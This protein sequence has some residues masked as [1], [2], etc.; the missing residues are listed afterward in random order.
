M[1]TFQEARSFLLQHRT[2]YDAAV[3]GFRWPDPVPFNW[4]LD[5]FDAELARDAESKDRAGALDRRCR[6][7]PRDKTFVRGAVAPLQPGREF[8][9]RAGP[10]ARRSSVAAARQCRSAVGDHAGGDQARRGGDPRDHA[11]DA[12]RIA[13]PAR[14]RPRQGRGGVAGPGREIR[15]ASAATI[16]FVSS[17]ARRRSTRAGC[18]Y[19]Q[20][21][22]FPEAFTPDGADRGRRSDAAVFHL[23]HHGETE[24]GAAQPAQLSR[25]RA[26]DD[27]LARACSRA[28]SI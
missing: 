6:Q 23:G 3:K 27:V 2:D 11:F 8:P 17:S 19:E 14:S 18:R 12:G 24:A 28:M 15:Q 10:Q 4:A 5:W 20:A 1:T 13:R 22:D 25:R 16:S 21:A 9:A 7:Q 26:V